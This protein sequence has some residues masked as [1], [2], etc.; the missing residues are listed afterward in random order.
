MPQQCVLVIFQQQ[1]QKQNAPIC[2]TTSY[3][4]VTKSSNVLRSIDHCG[5]CIQKIKTKKNKCLYQYESQ[6][7]SLRSNTQQ[8]NKKQSPP[9]PAHSPANV[10]FQFILRGQQPKRGRFTKR[11]IARQHFRPTGVGCP[12]H[13]VHRA[14]FLQIRRRIGQGSQG[15][16]KIQFHQAGVAHFVG[17]N[18]DG[19]GGLVGNGPQRQRNVVQKQRR[20]ASK[21]FYVAHQPIDRVLNLQQIQQTQQGTD[22]RHQ[23]TKHVHENGAQFVAFR[24]RGQCFFRF[25]TSGRRRGR[26]DGKRKT[27]EKEENRSMLGATN[28]NGTPPQ[29]GPSMVLA[30][31]STESHHHTQDLAIVL[32]LLATKPTHGHKEPKEKED[33]PQSNAR[34]GKKD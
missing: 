21:H 30:W 19:G 12:M 5:H 8:N 6:R 34:S 3:S 14:Q 10:A 18:G 26:S 2:C 4:M 17:H 9:P 28:S 16:I 29:S 27:T 24:K 22:A 11:T 33:D 25:A 1:E 31:M 7:A 32:H 23:A 13:V 20:V 15:Q